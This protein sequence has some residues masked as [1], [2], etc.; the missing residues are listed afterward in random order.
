LWRFEKSI[1]ALRTG[2]KE[3]EVILQRIKATSKQDYLK[4]ENHNFSHIIHDYTDN[5]KGF[6]QWKN[7]LEER[8]V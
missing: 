6:I 2:L 7:A 4:D 5:K 3:I 8:L 1:E